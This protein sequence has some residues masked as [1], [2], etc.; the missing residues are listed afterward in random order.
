MIDRTVEIRYNKRDNSTYVRGVFMML[1][2]MMTVEYSR[3]RNN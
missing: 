3:K 1:L 2:I